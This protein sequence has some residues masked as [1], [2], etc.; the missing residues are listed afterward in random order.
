LREKIISVILTTEKT[1]ILKFYKYAKLYK[2]Y[3]SEIFILT[4]N[5]KLKEKFK[6]LKLKN[7]IFF[8]ETE[9]EIETIASIVK[10]INFDEV[11]FLEMMDFLLEKRR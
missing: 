1:P 2:N 8:T 3:F 10:N 6:D 4:D 7:V 5:E 11:M 9:K